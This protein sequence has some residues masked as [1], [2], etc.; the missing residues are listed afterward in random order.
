MSLS[1][2]FGILITFLRPEKDVYLEI[3][4]HLAEQYGVTMDRD[5]LIQKAEAHA[6]RRNGRSRGRR[7]NS[8]S[9]A[10]RCRALANDKQKE[11]L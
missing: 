1:D 3:V 6:L 10:L 4:L 9:N 5:E 11:T 8:S 2:R 7:G